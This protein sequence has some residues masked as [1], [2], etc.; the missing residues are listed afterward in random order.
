VLVAVAFGA[1]QLATVVADPWLQ[2]GSTANGRATVT[3]LAALATDART[4]GVYG[5]YS[6]LSPAG[7]AV[8]FA[9]PALFYVLFTAAVLGKA[10]RHAVDG[11][12]GRGR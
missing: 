2:N 3:S 9:A 4:I 7:G 6:A 8:A 5:A 11:V 12:P 1:C 10:W